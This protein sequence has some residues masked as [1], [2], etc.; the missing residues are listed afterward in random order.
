ME[1]TTNPIIYIII[2]II[3]VL[4]GS[5]AWAY[6][7]HKA[8][9]N[10][11]K[12]EELSQSYKDRIDSLI[13]LCEEQKNENTIRIS[14]LEEQIE[15]ERNEYKEQINI[16]QLNLADE[17][18]KNNIFKERIYKLEKS[19]SNL[20]I[21]LDTI[22]KENMK[23]YGDLKA[24]RATNI[25]LLEEL[26]EKQEENNNLTRELNEARRANTKLLEEIY[27]LKYKKT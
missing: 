2:T 15:K 14:K 5:G 27:S 7:L 12:D 18:E 3:S 10:H 13:G 24:E 21:E 20:N 4:G 26:K 19:I 8:R 1:E 17:V 11:Q 25:R 16:I 23:L 6:Y 22:R 9:V